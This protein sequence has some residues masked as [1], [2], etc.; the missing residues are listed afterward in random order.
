M[1]GMGWQEADTGVLPSSCSVS[2]SEKFVLLLFVV[3]VCLLLLCFL[4]ADMC[5]L[6]QSPHTHPP[7]ARG[8][9]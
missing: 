6:P 9:H 7:Q 8:W 2:L 4:P 5:S 1:L 3:F